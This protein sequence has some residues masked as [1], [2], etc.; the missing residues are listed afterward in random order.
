MHSKHKR[1]WLLPQRHQTIHQDSLS[2]HNDSMTAIDK[3]VKISKRI[4][5]TKYINSLLWQNLS[6]RKKQTLGLGITLVRRL[7]ERSSSIA[8][9]NPVP[10]MHQYIRQTDQ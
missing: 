9:E 8:S 4:H 1:R 7:A 10:V 3:N 2:L 5:R 6:G